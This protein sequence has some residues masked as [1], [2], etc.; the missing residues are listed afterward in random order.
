MVAS[1]TPEKPVISDEWL[2]SHLTAPDVRVLDCTYFMAGSPQT[3]RQLYDAHHIPGS[4]FFDIDDIADSE[5]ALPHRALAGIEDETL[6]DRPEALI[7]RS[8]RGLLRRL[9]EERGRGEKREKEAERAKHGGIHGTARGA[10]KGA[11][12]HLGF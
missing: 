3:G 8:A 2:K 5:I 6:V 10:C 7:D 4:R 11:A 12:P 9:G 1:F